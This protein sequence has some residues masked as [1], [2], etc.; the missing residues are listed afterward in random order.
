MDLALYPILPHSASQPIKRLLGEVLECEAQFY[1]ILMHWGFGSPISDFV[2]P[3]DS[4]NSGVSAT[5][6]FSLLPVT[7]LCLGFTVMPYQ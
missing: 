1:T 5:S 2:F 3:R 4:V 6:L 7:A